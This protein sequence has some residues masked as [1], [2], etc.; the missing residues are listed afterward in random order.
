[1]RS[2]FSVAYVSHFLDLSY[3]I[4]PQKSY[5]KII[6]FSW[7]EQNYGYNWFTSKL[8]SVSDDAV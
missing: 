2:A 1:M 4:Y 8:L 3:E 5:G 7:C 6:I